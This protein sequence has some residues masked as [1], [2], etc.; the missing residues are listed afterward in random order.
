MNA[1]TLALALTIAACQSP[2]FAQ[3]SETV[4]VRVTNVEAVVTD[5][6]GKPVRG[7]TKDDFEI[8][9]DGVKQEISNF[10]EISEEVSAATLVTT[11]TDS[12][13]PAAPQ[14]PSNFRRRLITIFIDNASLEM[15]NRNSIL[16]SLKKFLSEQVRP[17]DAVSLVSWGNSLTVELEPTS[18]ANA[19]AAAVDRLRTRAPRVGDWR[20]EM[21]SEIL[22]LIAAY[23]SRHPPSKP[24]I[25]RGI[26]IVG[27]H[28]NRTSTEMR[29]KVAAIQSV[30]A[31]MRG[32]EGRKVLVMLTQGLSHNPGEDA[33]H[34]LDTVRDEFDG[35]EIFNP[36]SESRVYDLHNLTNEIAAAANAAGI[37][38]YPIHAGGKGIGI[39]DIDASRSAHIGLRSAPL[40]DTSMQTLNAIAE[41]TGGKALTGST[42]WALAFNTVATDLSTYYSLGY[43]ATGERQDRMKSVN[44]RLKKRGYTIRTRKAVIEKTA[45]SE[46][47][48][49]VM[50]NLFYST[51][52]NDLGVQAAAGPAV[53]A[54]DANVTVPLTITIPM[55]T[56][57]LLPDGDDLV[58]R[59]S[60]FAA[61]LR[62]D[63]AVSRVAN[64]TQQFRFPAS[65]LAR[66]KELTIKLDVTMDARTGAISVGVVDE[67]SRATGY[68]VV[69]LAQAQ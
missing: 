35:G 32:L 66:R 20:S 22:G 33:F 37:T 16:P 8:L 12:G 51:P 30:I 61:F 15:G 62:Q 14:A 19:I 3:F 38:L 5:R 27:S 42:N 49:A 11:A 56:L 50:A 54:A 1:R 29:Q 24:K 39:N 41:D 40:S 67:T 65:S 43:R 45:A 21:E 63:G 4:E 6:A 57:T 55:Q 44:V 60:V 10:A 36:Q 17:G 28:V 52:Q 13:A 48:D 68:T 34:F 69:K 7:L 59:C 9:E 58:G 26:A 46:M 23:K 47:S 25:S 2:L 31:A 64:Q 18:D 53:A